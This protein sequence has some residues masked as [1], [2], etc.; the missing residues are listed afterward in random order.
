MDHY[1][2]SIKSST[3]SEQL[4]IYTIFGIKEVMF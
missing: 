2:F 1:S 3:I 4:K